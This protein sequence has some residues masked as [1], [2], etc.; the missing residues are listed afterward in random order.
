MQKKKSQV[1][2]LISPI[3]KRQYTYYKIDS[4]FFVHYMPAKKIFVLNQ[5]AWTIIRLFLQGSGMEQIRDTLQ[6]DY[7]LDKR[8]NILRDI[9]AIIDEFQSYSSVETTIKY[10]QHQHKI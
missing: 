1:H 9:E 2:N 7:Q 8:Y 4:E 10:H 6:K 3:A 5:T